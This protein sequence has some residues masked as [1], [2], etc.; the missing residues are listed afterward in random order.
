MNNQVLTNVL[1]WTWITF[2]LDIL[3]RCYIC[4]SKNIFDKC[5]FKTADGINVASYMYVVIYIRFVEIKR[6]T[7]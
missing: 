4:E 6:P 3:S 2:E 7:N 1:K 5:L